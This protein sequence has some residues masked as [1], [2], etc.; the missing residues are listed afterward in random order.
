[1]SNTAAAAD[2]SIFAEIKTAP[3][4][5]ILGMKQLFLADSDPRKVNVSIGA[6]RTDEGKPYVLKCV[7]EAEQ[8]ILNDTK[9]DKEYLTQRGL[10]SFCTLAREVMLGKDCPAIAANR[11]AT[12]QSLSGTGGL[13]VAATFAKN[14][15]KPPA[16][17]YPAPTWSNHLSIFSDLEMTAKKYRY[18]CPSTR[19]LDFEG[20]VADLSTAT[21]GSIVLLHACAHNPTGVDPTHD[22][23]REIASICRKRGLLAWFDSAYQGFA[24]GSLEED[25]W[26]VRHF[27]AEGLE[28][29]VCQSFAK[30]IGLYGERVGTFSVV[31]N[32]AAT[33]Q[34]ILSQLDVI[35]RTL[36]S[37]PPLHGAR[38]VEHVLRDER[39]TQLWHDEMLVMSGRI[40]EM[41]KELHDALIELKT[42]GS[43]EH[44][45]QQ[46]GMFSFTGLTPEQCE[47]MIKKH[48]IYLLKSGRIS[49]AGVT[50]HNVKYLADAIDDVVRTL[51]ATL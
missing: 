12:I 39:L 34:P 44:I 36:Y 42:P 48:H 18:W 46:I 33:V 47:I 30:N 17:Y 15:L 8:Q 35:V 4:D 41:R 3:A 21:P 40:K 11:V 43:W 2:P 9:L 19:G 10:Q 6:Y 28:V 7:R 51:P 45:T 29:M 49:M 1:M 38:I 14:F 50:S 20:L 37:S 24:S 23:W 16:V 31:V 26:A 25:A 27:I 13:R 5:P 22:Q 32:D